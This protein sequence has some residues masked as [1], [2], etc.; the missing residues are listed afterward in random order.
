MTQNINVLKRQI[1]QKNILLNSMR[2][3]PSH[4][5][6]TIRKIENELDS[7]LYKF[8]KWLKCS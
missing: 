2:H 7:L 3:N 5:K 1:E 6:E 4:E 8:Y